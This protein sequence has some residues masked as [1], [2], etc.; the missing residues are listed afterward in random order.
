MSGNIKVG[1]AQLAPV[2]LD[3]AATLE[4]VKAAMQE[5]AQAQTDLLVFGE[6][7]LPGYPFWLALTEGAKWDL[8]INKTLHAHYAQNAIQ[9]EAGELE[10]VCVL[11]KQL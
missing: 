11:A 9:I 10:A 5:A 2:W 6:G 3:S 1:M 8:P 7:F 4:K